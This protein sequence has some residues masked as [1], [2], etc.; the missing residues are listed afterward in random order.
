M[1]R[2]AQG[3]TWL[4]YQ[5]TQIENTSTIWGSSLRQRCPN[6]ISAEK[7]GQRNLCTQGPG[8]RSAGE[9]KGWQRGSQVS[10]DRELMAESL[11]RGSAAPGPRLTG[12]RQGP[13]RS[14]QQAQ[15]NLQPFH[16][17]RG[18]GPSKLSPGRVGTSVC[19]YPSSDCCS[20]LSSPLAPPAL[21][22]RVVLL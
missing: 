20:L 15:R 4:L 10:A 16:S 22:F 19:E 7:E 21:P 6:L 13:K 18:W 3:Y 14:G 8:W 11:P 9:P 12:F 5:T 1:S 17:A 2:N